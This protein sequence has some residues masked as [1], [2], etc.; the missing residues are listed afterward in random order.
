MHLLTKSVAL[1]CAKQG[2]RIR[3]NCVMP[4]AIVTDMLRGNLREGQSEAELFAET[5]SRHPIGRLGEPR[6]VADAV[7]FLASNEAA[8]MTGSELIV[9]G[10]L[11]A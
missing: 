2:Y 8:F 3:V 1:H 10:G 7:A 4:G 6:D 5:Q 11:S 9:D